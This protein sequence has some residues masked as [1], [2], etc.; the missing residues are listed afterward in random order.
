MSCSRVLRIDTSSGCPTREGGIGGVTPPNHENLSFFLSEMRMILGFLLRKY[1][2][3][4]KN[5]DISSMLAASGHH[6]S[7]NTVHR[8]G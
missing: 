1:Y 3:A 4:P 2:V 5:R 6:C 8:Y 7:Y